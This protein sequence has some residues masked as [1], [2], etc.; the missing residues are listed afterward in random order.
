MNTTMIVIWTILIIVFAIVEAATVGLTSIWFALGSLV[1]LIATALHAPL[2]LQITIFAVVSIVAIIFTR[3][4][5]SKYINKRAMATNADR[6]IGQHATVTV[7]IDNIKGQGMVNIAGRDWTA[8][9]FDGSI[10]EEG[11]DTL[12]K[13]IEGVKAIVSPIKSGENV[14]MK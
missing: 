3:P 13:S 2:W 10:I 8:R 7:R 12:V 14:T 4:L 5:A 11:E 9:S 1:A 6:T